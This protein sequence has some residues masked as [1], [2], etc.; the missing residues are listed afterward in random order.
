MRRVWPSVL[1]IR[2]S[3]HIA[4]GNSVDTIM[5]NVVLALLPAAAFAVYVFGLAA[6]LTLV[7]ATAAA[8]STEHLACAGCPAPG[9]RSGTGRWRSPACSTG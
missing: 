4:R 9:P 1:E 2:T 7:A 3:P 8:W 5:F 6:L